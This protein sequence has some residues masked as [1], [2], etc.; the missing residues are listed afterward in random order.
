VSD[1]VTEL[2]RVTRGGGRFVVGAL[3]R[4][5]AWGVVNRKQ[6]DEA[7]WDHATFLAEATL[8][9][10]GEVFGP[11]TCHAALYAPDA[12]LG[13]RW[14]GPIAERLGRLLTPHHGAFVV[15]RRSPMAS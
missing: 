2:A 7:P 1:T 13:L 14:W 4:R 9:R 8:R 11:T 12:W 15:A 5:S 10:V 3:N 6:F